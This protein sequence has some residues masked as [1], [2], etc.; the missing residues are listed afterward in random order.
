MNFG[1]NASFDSATHEKPIEKGFDELIEFDDIEA[2]YNNT[3]H[4]R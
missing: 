1:L 4:P 2:I 3:V